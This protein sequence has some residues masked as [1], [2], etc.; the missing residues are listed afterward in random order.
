M[1]VVADIEAM[2]AELAGWR[3]DLHAHPELG[4]EENRTADFVAAKLA[5]FGVQVYRGIGKTGLVGVLREGNALP[6]RLV[7]A[8]T[9]TRCRFWS[10]T[11]LITVPLTKAPCT[12]VDMM[13]IPSCC[14]PPQSI[15]QPRVIFRVR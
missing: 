11:P 1:D 12:P 13:V 4:F 5:T 9:W 14:W 7:C 10:R 6:A 3:R 8:R 15:W 2:Q